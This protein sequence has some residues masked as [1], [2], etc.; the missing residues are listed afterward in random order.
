MDRDMLTDEDLH[1]YASALARNGFSGPNAW[2]MNGAANLEFAHRAAKGR[3]LSMPVLFFHAAYDYTCD[4][5]GSRLADPMR[6]ACDDLTELTLQTGHWMAQE[7]PDLVNAGL[8]RWLAL[9][10]PQHWAI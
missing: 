2:Y 9:K 10:F 5:V 4:T 8:A 7:R 6:E 1:R 3:R